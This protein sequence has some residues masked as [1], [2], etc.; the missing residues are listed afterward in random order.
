MRL[1]KVYIRSNLTANEAQNI[2]NSMIEEYEDIDTTID[3]NLQ[4]E[5]SIAVGKFAAETRYTLIIYV[6]DLKGE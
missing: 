6:Y 2:V 1:K 4:I 5:N 3:F